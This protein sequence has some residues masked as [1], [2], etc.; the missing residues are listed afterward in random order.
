MT[1][2]Q[3]LRMESRRWRPGRKAE[4]PMSPILPKVADLPLAA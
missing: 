3:I 4:V 1:D 2:D